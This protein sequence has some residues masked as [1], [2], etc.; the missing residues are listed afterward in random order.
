MPYKMLVT[1]VGVGCSVSEQFVILIYL[2]LKMVEVGTVEE[3]FVLDEVLDLLIIVFIER[4]L[5]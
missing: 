2:G 1:E 5:L 3:V 4:L